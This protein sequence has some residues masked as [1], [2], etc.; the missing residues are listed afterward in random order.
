M[1][2]FLK[3]QARA[4]P[5]RTVVYLPSETLISVKPATG[6]RLFKMGLS[7]LQEKKERKKNPTCTNPEVSSYA[8]YTVCARIT[9]S[10]DPNTDSDKTAAHRKTGP[11]L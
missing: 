7:N 8:T 5:T 3:R 11:F 2:L 4:L 9:E 10:L 6:F 1:V